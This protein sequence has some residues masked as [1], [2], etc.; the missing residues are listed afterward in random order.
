MYVGWW[1]ALGTACAQLTT[2]LLFISS[3]DPFHEES[4][5]QYTMICSEFSLECEE[6]KSQDS[7]G[8]LVFALVLTAWLLK[9]IVGSLKL[10]VLAVFKKN[11]DFFFAS[12][13]IFIVTA[14]SAWTSI[15][16]EYLCV[17]AS[18]TLIYLLIQ[19][20]TFFFTTFIDNNAF[21]TK[22]TELI[23][24]AVILLFVNE[25]DERLYQLVEAC[26]SE[27]IKGE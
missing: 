21:S 7:F 6:G 3:A 17:C 5:V 1:L 13:I 15:Y 11:I 26:N 23:A 24:N 22:N 16:C 8:Y 9:D 10:F 25:L 18:N 4:D 27:W 2:L 19:I 14:F 12:I 20:L